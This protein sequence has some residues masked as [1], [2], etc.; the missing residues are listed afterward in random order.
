MGVQK[1]ITLPADLFVCANGLV[2]TRGREMPT[3]AQ[4]TGMRGLHLV[5]AELSKREFIVSTTSRNA[6]GADLL[7]TD[8][9]C[10]P[11]YAVQVKTN[12]RGFRFWL[13]NKRTSGIRSKNFVYAF[14]NLK[15]SGPEYYLV[16]SRVVA[17]K[18]HVS[19]ASKTRKSTWYSV[20]LKDVSKFKDQWDVF[21]KI[22]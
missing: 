8:A 1:C 14:V 9:K 13:A 22:L 3:K 6:E 16:P 12:A 2:P 4:F 11:T 7:I 20:Y 10:R 19:K 18:V 5:A 21:K 15:K 17:G